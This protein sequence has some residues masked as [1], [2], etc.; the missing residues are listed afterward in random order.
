M[1]KYPDGW[2]TKKGWAGITRYRPIGVVL[3]L[4]A[5]TGCVNLMAERVVD[6]VIA[7]AEK[8]TDRA[9]T[10]IDAAVALLERK[11][12]RARKARCRLPFSALVRYAARGEKETAILKRD[13]ALTVSKATAIHLT[14]DPVE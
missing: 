13:C 4:L 1:H 3:V 11:A 7:H 8:V 9:M 2:L 12:Y 14:D 6:G 5:L 10:G